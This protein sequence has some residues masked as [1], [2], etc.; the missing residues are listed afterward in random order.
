[1]RP[2]CALVACVGVVLL[3]VGPR[4]DGQGQKGKSPQLKLEIRLA[5]QEPAAGLEEVVVP[6]TKSKIYVHKKA[7]IGNADI[8][9]A[10]VVKN[11]YGYPAV[12]L[13]FAEG[14][15]D[16]VA[17]FS[18]GN[19]DKIAAVFVDGK[20]IDAPVIREKFSD[21]TEIRGAQPLTLEQAERIV[22]GL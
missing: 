20:L 2:V 17:E 21:R 1:M 4:A 16:K 7:A 15:R 18:G 10:R 13:V 8:A 12:E 11:T 5:Q 19:I 3:A 14:S 6:R 9:Q 22:K